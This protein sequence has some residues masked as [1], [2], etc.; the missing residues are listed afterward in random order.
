MSELIFTVV[1]LA[2]TFCTVL[3]KPIE[4]RKC[5]HRIFCDTVKKE[6]KQKHFLCIEKVKK[7]K[8]VGSDSI[9]PQI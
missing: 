5:Q 3:D 6:F 9:K 7:K 8:E 1:Y 2:S 4:I